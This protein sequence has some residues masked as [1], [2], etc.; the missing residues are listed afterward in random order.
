MHYGIRDYMVNKKNNYRNGRAKE[1]RILKNL[2]QDG[3]DIVFRSAGS[4]SPIDC[5]G[6]KMMEK[7]IKFF[8]SKP[9]SMSEKARKKLENEL[10]W[11]NDQFECSFEVV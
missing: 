10:F 8:Q 3:F 4:H 6:I 1:Y 7:K 2:K 11:L 5:I 9:K